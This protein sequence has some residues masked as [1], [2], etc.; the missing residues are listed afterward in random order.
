M[1]DAGEASRKLLTR[2]LDESMTLKD[3]IEAEIRNLKQEKANAALAVVDLTDAVKVIREFQKGFD[4]RPM[5]EQKEILKDV[6]KRIVIH[7]TK[8]VCG[9]YG[10]EGDEEIPFGPDESLPEEI[11]G[12]PIFLEQYRTRVRPGNRLVEVM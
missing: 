1:A 5:S 8:I 4:G 2:K 10:Q 7:P 11:S 12:R 9:I 6:M 3:S